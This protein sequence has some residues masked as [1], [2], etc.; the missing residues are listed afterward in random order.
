[1]ASVEGKQK[2]VRERVRV[3]IRTP[4]MFAQWAIHLSAS[5]RDGHTSKPIESIVILTA[6]ARDP[7]GSKGDEAMIVG[8]V[9]RIRRHMPTCRVALA[10]A[11]IDPPELLKT[12]EVECLP[13]WRQP[14]KLSRVMRELSAF[15]ALFVIGADVMDGY[16]STV[17]SL[18][19]WMTADLFSRQGK[20]SIIG[21]CS[22]NSTATLATRFFLRRCVSHGL[23]ICIRDPAS[24]KRFSAISRNPGKMVT[25]AAFL[26]Q[27]TTSNSTREI[28]CWIERQRASGRVICGL[29]I[30]P[31]LVPD[32]NPAKLEA[33]V[34]AATA[35]AVRLVNESNASVLLIPHDFRQSGQSDLQLLKKV[36]AGT[37]LDD[38]VCLTA[39]LDRSSEIKFAASCCDLV[40]TGRMHLAIGALGSGVPV[41]VVD[42]QD[43]FIG[44]FEHFGLSRNF[45][46]QPDEAMNPQ[47]FYKVCATAIGCREEL[48][49]QVATRL[50][51]VGARSE[52]NLE[53]VFS[54]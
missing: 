45:V 51:A 20:I 11:A 19:L 16:Y 15:D 4:A 28:A 24:F 18:R 9:Q 54:C 42:Y 10:I 26:L 30:H 3:A 47:V 41:V 37:D 7:L 6:D 5:K 17:T 13:I 14:W 27:P 23:D 34:Q 36:L 50:P 48:R 35:V 31:M 40:F 32:R 38:R 39:N 2:T 43:K 46:I 49:E 8:V 44:L 33:F 53:A 25:D 21:G 1:M 29:N 52:R 12:L 22:F